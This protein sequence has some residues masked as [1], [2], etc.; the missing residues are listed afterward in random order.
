[1]AFSCSAIL[2]GACGVGCFCKPCKEKI[3]L[4]IIYGIF[5]FFVWVIILVIGIVVTAVSF[6]SPEAIQ[7][8]CTGNTGNSR[9]AFISD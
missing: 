9:V 7:S 1:M 4:P 6:F 5:L 8:F 3:A 2:V